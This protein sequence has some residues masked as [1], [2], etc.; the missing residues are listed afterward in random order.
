ME[1]SETPWADKMMCSNKKGK[2]HLHFGF[3]CPDLL[4]LPAIRRG[5]VSHQCQWAPAPLS[6]VSW[7]RRKRR[8]RYAPLPT[9]LALPVCHSHLGSS[10]H[11]SGMCFCRGVRSCP[12][13]CCRLSSLIFHLRAFTGW[14]CSSWAKMTIKTSFKLSGRDLGAGRPRI[15]PK[16]AV[17]VFRAALRL[18]SQA[19]RHGLWLNSRLALG[20]SV[21]DP[22]CRVSLAWCFNLF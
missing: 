6:I 14:T 9:C 12:P 1:R 13:I 15:P 8:R 5:C 21:L 22:A 10:L 18:G 2:T 17:G 3:S 7:R 4:C 20:L 19:A 16:R 11:R